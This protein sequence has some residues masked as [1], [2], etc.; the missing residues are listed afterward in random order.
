MHGIPVA[1]P[2]PGAS[3]VPVAD[4]HPGATPVPVAAPDP[5]ANP[6]AVPFMHEIPIADADAGAVAVPFTHAVS[7]TDPATGAVAVPV[8]DPDRGADAVPVADPDTSAVAV[9]I[10]ALVAAARGDRPGQQ[11]DPVPVLDGAAGRTHCLRP[12]AP[13]GTG[14]NAVWLGDQASRRRKTASP[15]MTAAAAY[16]QNTANPIHGENGC[17]PL[18]WL[19]QIE[20]PALNG[21]H[22]SMSTWPHQPL[23]V[24]G[25][26]W[27]RIHSTHISPT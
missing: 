23:G 17:S 3:P 20:E 1:D 19:S 21:I 25:R 5:G 24:P 2:D 26:N 22:L 11:P 15:Q 18:A 7:L 4:P 8:A 6:V 9:A 27:L 12:V 16:A 13:P 14:P 10:R